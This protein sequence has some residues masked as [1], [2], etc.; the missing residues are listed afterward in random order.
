M[1]NTLSCACTGEILAKDEATASLFSGADMGTAATTCPLTGSASMNQP[2]SGV[3][4]PSCSP[5]GA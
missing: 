3:S 4:P 2:S 5:A 1:M